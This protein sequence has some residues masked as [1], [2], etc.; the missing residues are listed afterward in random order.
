MLLGIAYYASKGTLSARTRGRVGTPL[1][2]EG[3]S[4]TNYT[5]STDFTILN[6]IVGR[7]TAKYPSL[8]PLCN[9]L[10]K[11][12]NIPSMVSTIKKELNTVI[13]LMYQGGEYGK[14][15]INHWEYRRGSLLDVI[16]SNKK[17]LIGAELNMINFSSYLFRYLL[18]GLIGEFSGLNKILTLENDKRGKKKNKSSKQKVE[19]NWRI[20]FKNLPNSDIHTI[21]FLYKMKKFERR[22]TIQV[23]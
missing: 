7:V 22:R 12:N 9:S 4:P 11:I 10:I 3:K 17:V 19:T 13:A 18:E 23:V 6:N 8:I 20:L 21:L 1:K 15:S 2:P 16:V 5:L 14:A